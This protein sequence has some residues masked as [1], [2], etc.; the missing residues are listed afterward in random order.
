MQVF[1]SFSNKC[2]YSTVSLSSNSLYISLSSIL[3]CYSSYC[4]LRVKLDKVR[5]VKVRVK[6]S[7]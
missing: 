2:R 6:E 5:F 3:A 4:S 7:C 1:W